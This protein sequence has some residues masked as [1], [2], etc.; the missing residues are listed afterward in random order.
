MFCFPALPEEHR[1]CS[2]RSGETS[3]LKAHM[4]FDCVALSAKIILR[5]VFH[6][7]E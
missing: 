6:G 5:R 4:R 1:D 3:S 2:E 7:N